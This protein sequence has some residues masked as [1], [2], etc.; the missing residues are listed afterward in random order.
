M[1][2]PAGAKP[3]GVGLGHQIGSGG[4]APQRL[5]GDDDGEQADLRRTEFVI[6][7]WH[8]FLAGVSVAR[9]ESVYGGS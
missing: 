7:C 8:D 9:A 5:L 2:A 1:I 3:A 6:R 4:L